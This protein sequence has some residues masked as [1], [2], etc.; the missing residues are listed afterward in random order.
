[1][2]TQIRGVLGHHD[3]MEGPRWDGVVTSRAY[4]LLDGLIGLDRGHRHPEKIAHAITPR[5]AASANTTRTMSSTLLSCS[6]NGL[7]PTT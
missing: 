3:E 6:R 5:V 2:A 1:M 7:K 4:V